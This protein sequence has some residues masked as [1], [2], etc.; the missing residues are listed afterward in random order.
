MGVGMNEEMLIKDALRDLLRAAEALVADTYPRTPLPRPRK[1]WFCGNVY[2][3]AE[4]CENC[5]KNF[6]AASIVVS[7]S[8]SATYA[9]WADIS[10]ISAQIVSECQTPR[11][12]SAAIRSIRAATAWCEARTAG[13]QRQ[14]QEILRQQ[15]RY[16][17]ELEAEEALRALK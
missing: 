13:R 7:R 5:S 6:T 4:Y 14:A 16:V 2:W 3:P 15:A 1:F 9:L 12:V 8:H 11:E 10:R 17:E